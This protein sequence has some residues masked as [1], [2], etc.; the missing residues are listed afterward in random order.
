[1]A[2][3]DAALAELKTKFAE[4]ICPA[5]LSKYTQKEPAGQA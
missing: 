2:V 3:S 5:C 1:V 4:C